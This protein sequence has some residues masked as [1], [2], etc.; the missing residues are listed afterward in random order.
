MGSWGIRFA[1][2]RVLY[3][4]SLQRDHRAKCHIVDQDSMTPMSMNLTDLVSRGRCSPTS[5]SAGLV[6]KP[7]VRSFSL[8]VQGACHC[9]HRMFTAP[10]PPTSQ[11]RL[12]RCAAQVCAPLC[13]VVVVKSCSPDRADDSVEDSV[14]PMKERYVGMLSDWIR[15][16]G[17]SCADSHID[18]L[19]KFMGEG[20]S[21]IPSCLYG[22]RVS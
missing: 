20:R 18:F 10:L 4:R 19:F 17:E 12:L 2:R 9:G 11:I 5:V 13:R 14:K 21:E 8:L 16:H 22:G 1:S 6:A 3:F 15:G 7:P